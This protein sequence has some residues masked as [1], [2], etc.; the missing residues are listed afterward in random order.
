MKTAPCFLA[1]IACG[2]PTPQ[3][4]ANP[5]VLWL[6]ANGDEMHVRLQAT[7]PPPF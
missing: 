3:P 2:S 5:P 6:N 1:L 4:A 7:E